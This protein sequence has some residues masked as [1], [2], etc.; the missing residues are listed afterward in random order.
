MPPLPPV[1]RA[2]FA[3][4]SKKLISPYADGAGLQR[5]FFWFLGSSLGFTKLNAFGPVVAEA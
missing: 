3:L 1:T 2:A 5:Y 4:R